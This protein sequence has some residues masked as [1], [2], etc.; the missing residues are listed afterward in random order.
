MARSRKTRRHKARK[1]TAKKRTAK[2]RTAKKRTARKRRT[3][4]TSRTRSRRRSCYTDPA[5]RERIRR[6]ILAGSK[7]GRPGQWSAVKANLV[8]N[9][10]RAAGG[11]Y[12]GRRSAAQR[13]MVK[14]NTERWRTLDGRPAVRGSRTARFLPDAAWRAL[15]PA[16][17][18]A[19]NRKKLSGRRQFIANTRAARAAGK[20][21]RSRKTKK[22]K[23]RTTRRKSTRRK[24]KRRKRQRR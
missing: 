16:Q 21:A 18:R 1:R 8:A 24:S 4:R 2:K 11:R 13:S 14:W 10:Y 23:K 15:T 19:T 22:T 7:G 17:R 5:L 9:A 20:R 6:R 3:K 12:C